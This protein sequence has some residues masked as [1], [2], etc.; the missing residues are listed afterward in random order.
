M[1]AYVYKLICRCLRRRCRQKIREIDDGV[2]HYK[3]KKI[4]Y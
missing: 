1:Q 3:E 4:S 2:I